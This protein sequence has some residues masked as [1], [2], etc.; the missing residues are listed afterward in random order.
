MYLIIYTR[1]VYLNM[2]HRNHARTPAIAASVVSVVLAFAV[3]VVC[4]RVRRRRQRSRER[5]VPEQFIES[6]EHILPPTSRL[7]PGGAANAESFVVCA[8]QLVGGAVSDEA[9]LKHHVLAN[10][11]AD[12]DNVQLTDPPAVAPEESVAPPSNP[13]E[14]TQDEETVTLRLRRV[15]A[16]LE[17]LLT[18][19]LP[20][21]SLPSYCR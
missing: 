4:F 13:Q 20:E 16:Q 9:Q 18:Q 8:L 14:T 3:A 10:P 6:Q 1:T 11:R 17:A 12:S 2:P 5:R 21:G 15:E 19:G 7:K